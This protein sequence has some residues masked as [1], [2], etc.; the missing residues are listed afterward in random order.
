MKISNIKINKIVPS[1]RLVGF[2]SF[3]IEHEFFVGNIAIFQRLHKE[4]CRLVFPEKKVNDKKIPICY[5]I[6][7][8]TYFE[9]EKIIN[10]EFN[11]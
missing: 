10:E 3:L 8:E 4:G 9:I 11:K 6:N 2:V 1:K 5:P 7:K